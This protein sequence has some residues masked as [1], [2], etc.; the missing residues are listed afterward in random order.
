M[1]D[2]DYGDLQAQLNSLESSWPGYEQNGLPDGLEEQLNRVR[3]NIADAANGDQDGLTGA[4]NN[5]NLLRRLASS[6]DNPG[7][8]RSDIADIIQEIQEANGG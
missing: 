3:A 6:Y 2:P 7:T 8:F 4:V 1:P 5:L